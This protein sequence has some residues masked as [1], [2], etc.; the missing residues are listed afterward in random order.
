MEYLGG[1]D[2]G[3]ILFA[4]DPGQGPILFCGWWPWGNGVTISIRIGLFDEAATDE[5]RE[6]HR[7]LLQT[8]FSLSPAT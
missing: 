5:D 2:R 3:Q 6:A 1:L 7:Q 8:W 4:C